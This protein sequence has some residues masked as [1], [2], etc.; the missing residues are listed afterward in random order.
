MTRGPRAL[1]DKVAISAVDGSSS[2]AY[3]LARLKGNYNYETVSEQPE[4]E[5]NQPVVWPLSF[6]GGMASTKYTPEAATALINGG[7]LV[8]EPNI[9]R[10]RPATT[11]VTLTSASAPPKYFFEH[12][13]NDSGAD[14][15][16]PVLYV[17]DVESAALRVY[18]ISLKEGGDFN[19]ASGVTTTDTTLTDAREAWTTDEW[20]DDIVTCGGKAMTVTGNTAT[21]LTGSGGWSGGGNPGNGHSWI[22]RLGGFGHLLNHFAKAETPT[23]PMGKPARGL[24]NRWYLGRGDDSEYI[25]RLDSVASATAND[26]WTVSADADARH[27]QVV[28]NRV[29]RSTG[30]DE[31]CLLSRGSEG[32]TE[33]SWGGEHYVGEGYF[34]I[35]DLQEASGLLYVMKENGVFEWDLL[36]TDPE[37]IFPAIGQS[38]RNGQGSCYWHGGFLIPTATGLWWT[39]TGEP[40]GPDSNPNNTGSHISLGTGIDYLKGGRWHGV[41]PYGP[42]VY[43]IYLTSTLTTAAIMWGRER[44]DNDP[45]GWGPII[46]H[47][48][49]I[50]TADDADFHGI[51]VA[52]TA[53]FASGDIRPCLFYPHG[54][55]VRY[56]WLDNDGAPARRR[57]NIDLGT[58]GKVI[59]GV[60]DFGFPQVTKQL[61]FIEG[62][63]EDFGTVVGSFQF[64]V[65][66][67]SETGA[68]AV[69]ASPTITADGYFK[70]S[71]TQDTDDTA[72]SMLPEVVWTGTS[73]LTSTNGPH[74]RDVKIHAKLQPAVTRIW[75]FLMAVEDK[76]EKT[77]KKKLAELEACIGDLKKYELPDGRSFNGVM[78]KPRL[79]RDDEIAQLKE[80][81][82]EMPKFV[83]VVPVREMP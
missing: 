2:I 47:V 38:S 60:F 11:D 49:D 1:G 58:T 46:W 4:A 68:E 10:A 16:S 62:W 41:W 83:M 77:G 19:T 54:N 31:V 73:S 39:L 32:N 20:I 52:E 23:E 35:T 80:S 69:D 3:P 79:M 13:V 44:D 70:K 82:Q 12:V 48:I 37:N 56:Q 29:A 74:L 76:R 22:I 61:C 75:T 8:N 42:Y 45:L 78:D 34:E 15:A 21:V 25:Q 33:A 66:R 81:N 50:V 36:G 55:K 26:T 63:A 9:I 28:G 43:G 72:R 65:Y 14:E 30:K 5:P 18:R 7:M 40:V 64:N 24:N 57:G 27:L 71:W 6:H 67:D 51:Y 59:G 53:E 17:I